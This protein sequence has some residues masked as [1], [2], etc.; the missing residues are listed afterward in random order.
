MKP[1]LLILGSLSALLAV[2]QLVMGLL[3]KNGRADLKG[4]HQH[5]GETMVLVV[6]IYVGLS[7]AAILSTKK[8]DEI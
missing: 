8:R 7:L 4:L 1:S 3:I 5:S 2:A 6:L